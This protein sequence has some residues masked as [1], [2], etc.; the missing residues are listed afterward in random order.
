MANPVA[1][2]GLGFLFGGLVGFVLS[3]FMG[4]PSDDAEAYGASERAQSSVR[5][6][7]TDSRG[8]ESDAPRVE[9]APDSSDGPVASL[10]RKS[11]ERMREAVTATE[12]ESSVGNGVIDGIVRDD[13]GNPLAGAKVRASRQSER[14]DAE[15]SRRGKAQS[16]KSLDDELRGAAEGWQKQQAGMR[17]VTTAADGSYKFS[18][19]ADTM[20]RLT[21]S[22]DGYVVSAK[23]ASSNLRVGSHL[24]FEARAVAR[25]AVSAR[26]PDGRSVKRMNLEIKSTGLAG[27]WSELWKSDTPYVELVPG[28]YTI[29]AVVAKGQ[30]TANGIEIECASQEKTVDIVIGSNPGLDFDLT[31]RLGIRGYVYYGEDMSLS[32]GS[33]VYAQ[34]PANGTVDLKALAENNSRQWISGEQNRFEIMDLSAG[35]Y[36]V[37][38]VPGWNA[39]VLDHVICEVKDR[40]VEIEL[41]LGKIDLSTFLTATVKGP[42]GVPIANVNFNYFIE[43]DNNSWSNWIQPIQQGEGKFL[44]PPDQQLTDWYAKPGGSGKLR[45]SAHS[46]AFGDKSVELTKTQRE[47]TFEYGE[48]ATLDLTLTSY[49]GSGLE[50]KLDVALKRA[51]DDDN[52]RFYYGND[53]QK[54]KADGTARL[55]PTEIG[56]YVIELQSMGDNRW[57][58]RRVASQKITLVAGNNTATMTVPALYKL[59]ITVKGEVS[60]DGCWVSLQGN[61]TYD[62]QNPTDGVATFSNLSA[63]KYEI[64]A[65]SGG[66]SA[67]ASIELPGQTDVTLTLKK[68]NAMRVNVWNKDGY[69]GKLG[70]MEGDLIIGVDGTGFVDQQSMTLALAQAVSRQKVTLNLLRGNQSIDIE[71]EG[72]KLLEQ[73]SNGANWWPVAR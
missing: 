44:L 28:H 17:E 27:T 9:E 16:A 39:Q 18:D 46:D 40:I 8:S 65:Q 20:W 32:Q 49:L 45:L 47:A 1:A 14:S 10:D 4:A 51:G 33:V 58:R 13:K 29:R 41:D 5:T 62:N 73:N 50:G 55:G 48:A 19:L 67:S 71:V 25:V 42:R 70:L 37:G 34:V 38:V 7:S 68:P 59:A 57:N 61:D 53:D 15:A 3:S 72:P 21:A 23:G 52:Q 63:G 64:T 54:L 43:E 35:K 12:T 11:V 66:L 56:D 24:N 60:G 2:G 36:A 26:L 69:F 6:D 30:R 22:A 31:A